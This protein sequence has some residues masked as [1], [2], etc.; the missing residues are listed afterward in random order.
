MVISAKCTKLEVWSRSEFD[1][2][3]KKFLNKHNV[4]VPLSKDNSMCKGLC[5]YLGSAVEV[6]LNGCVHESVLHMNGGVY[7]TWQHQFSRG[8]D[9][10]SAARYH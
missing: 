8:I 4:E 5:V 6:V 2:M 7:S 10:F 1:K 9:D 3:T